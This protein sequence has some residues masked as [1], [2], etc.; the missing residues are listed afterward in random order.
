MRLFSALAHWCITQGQGIHSLGRECGLRSSTETVVQRGSDRDASWEL[1][2]EKRSKYMNGQRQR[3]SQ[4]EKSVIW[5]SD[6][7]N[8]VPRIAVG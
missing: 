3:N 7:Q 6:V 5:K 1:R 4:G 8:E 2:W